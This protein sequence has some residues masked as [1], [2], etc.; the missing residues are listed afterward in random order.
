MKLKDEILPGSEFGSKERARSFSWK[1]LAFR[2]TWYTVWLL[3]AAWTPPQA[4]GWRRFLLNLFGAKI[5][6]GARVYHSAKIWYPPNLVMGKGAVLG[7]NV[8]C[9]CMDQIVLE[10]YAEVAQH[11]HLVC[12]SHSVHT[13]D[14][15]LITK[16]IRICSFAWVASGAFVGPGVTVGRGA[17]LGAR[18]VAFEDLDEWGIYIGNPAEK[19]GERTKFHD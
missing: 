4:H 5:S 3:C 18:G 7:R 2:L 8:E 6:K 13:S 9:Y 11:V 1:I 12:G 10:D 19:K 14:F 15:Q 16:P 17:V